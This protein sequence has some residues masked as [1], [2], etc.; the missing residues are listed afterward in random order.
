MTARSVLKTWLLLGC[1]FGIAGFAQVYFASGHLVYSLIALF[2]GILVGLVG[3]LIRAVTFQR[4]DLLKVEGV[5]PRQLRIIASSFVIVLG[6]A[7]TVTWS[8]GAPPPVYGALI[9]S[10]VTLAFV[11]QL[12]FRRH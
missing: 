10:A 3:G 11:S 9:V 12:L 6:V 1:A 5:A 8:R 7:A 2:M 4:Y